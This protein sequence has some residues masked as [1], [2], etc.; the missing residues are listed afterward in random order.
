MFLRELGPTNGVILGI[1][2]FVAA[3]AIMFTLISRVG[4]WALV[5]EQYR[6]QETF[7][8][9]TWS[10]QKGQM[11]WMVGYNNCLTVGADP[12]GLY[13]SILFPFRLG[14]PP[15]FIPWRDISRASKKVLWIN[16]IELRLGREVPIPFRISYPLAQKLKSAAGASWPVEAAA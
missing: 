5:A 7:T 8:G 10:F 3:W 15:L 14:H 1:L 2:C 6:C 9:A 11:R 12:R 13:I 4:G 16:F